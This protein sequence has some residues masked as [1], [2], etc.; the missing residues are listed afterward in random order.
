MNETT[1]K[2]DKSWAANKYFYG[3]LI[4]L[5]LHFYLSVNTDL[6]EYTQHTDINIPTWYFY[7]VFAVDALAVLSLILIAMY[8]KIGVYAFPFFLIV[9]F[10]IH[11]YFLS[12]FLYSDVSVLFFFVGLGLL[13]VIP[14]WKDFR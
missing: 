12:T 14:R 13:V 11:N 5:G 8:K 7:I 9:H 2:L 10:L 6:A 4:F 3:I 1:T